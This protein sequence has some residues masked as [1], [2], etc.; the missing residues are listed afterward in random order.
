MPG[1]AAGDREALIDGGE[2]IG[3]VLRTREGV[4]PLFV[5]VGHRIGLKEAVEWVRRCCR[6]YRLPEPARA[7]HMAAGGHLDAW[8]AGRQSTEKTVG[9]TLR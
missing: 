9:L 1:Q 8:R 7:A 6:G 3:C 5:S 2:V 4:A